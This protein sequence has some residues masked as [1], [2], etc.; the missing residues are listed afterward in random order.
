MH[1]CN[2]K[3]FVNLAYAISD[4]LLND[5]AT[6]LCMTCE[7]VKSSFVVVIQFIIVVSLLPVFDAAGTAIGYVHD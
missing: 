5:V 6:G 4:I 2:E 7:N 3:V 1:E